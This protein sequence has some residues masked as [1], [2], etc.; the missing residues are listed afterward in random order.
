MDNLLNIAGKVMEGFNPATD[1][2]D[3]FEKLPDGEYTCLL[4]DV[5]KK[6]GKESGNAYLNL[7]FSVMEGDKEG[8]LIFVS[9]FFTDKTIERTVKTILKLAHD[10]GYELTVEAFTD[11]ETLAESLQSLCG[12]QAIVK[13]TT[14][15]NDF[16]NYKITPIE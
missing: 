13:Q 7:K 11:L 1:S 15:K 14:S 4:E 9:Y 10:F 5:V 6:V 2:A 16:T 12:N 8:R 3:D